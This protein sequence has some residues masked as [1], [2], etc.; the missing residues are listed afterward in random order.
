MNRIKFY[1]IILFV[2][3]LLL[4]TLKYYYFDV[5][6]LRLKGRIESVEYNIKKNMLITVSMKKHN[7]LHDWP[8]FQKNVEEGDSVYKEKGKYDIILIKKN[9]NEKIVCPYR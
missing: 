8:L 7:I 4:G 3:F 6:H 5:Y 9:T 1:V 2:C